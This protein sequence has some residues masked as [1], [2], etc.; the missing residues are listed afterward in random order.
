M[1]ERAI[2]F[3]AEYNNRARVPDHGVFIDGWH[4]DAAAY[5][6]TAVCELDLSYGP[7][8]R[9]RVDLFHADKSDGP[10]VLFLHGGYWQAFDK[11]SASHLARGANLRGFAVAVPSYPLAPQADLAEIVRSIEQAADFVA[12]RMQRPLIVAGH[13]A[14]GHL[15]ACLMARSSSAVRPVRAGMPISGL[16]DL[17]PLVSTSINK[18]LGLTTE[19]AARLSP[20]GWTPPP[21]GH[22]VAVVGSAES[23]EYHRQTHLIVESWH[24]LDGRVEIVPNAHHFSVVAGL[25]DP[26]DA[27]VDVLVELA[28]SA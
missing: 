19:D 16:F 6:A 12:R 25:A 23:A 5:R 22:V 15:A 14:G 27:L 2:D 13:S 17:T 26:G 10:V 18:A 4:K 24:E 7:G 21:G 20:C 9:H 11:S 28:A 1:T 8:E 3:E